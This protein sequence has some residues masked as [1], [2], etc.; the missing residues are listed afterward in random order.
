MDN[1][2]IFVTND[3]VNEF[4]K[5]VVDFGRRTKGPWSF[6]AS[7]GSLA[8]KLYQNLATNITFK[9]QAARIGFY[10]GDERVVDPDDEASNMFN[11]RKS[12]LEPLK[13]M[14]V[15]PQEFPPFTKNEFGRLSQRLHGN[16]ATDYKIFEGTAEDYGL[17]IQVAPKPWLIHLGVGQDGHTASLFPNSP[18]LF[19]NDPNKLYLANYDPSRT[20]PYCRLTLSLEAIS[21]A[22]LVII[23]ANG[24]GKSKI[25]EGLLDG[26]SP[27]PV[28][29]IRAAKVNLIIDYEAASLVDKS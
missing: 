3:I 22:E 15:I 14:G 28:A 21:Q 9:H 26:H 16:P 1:L 4:S 12:L 8:P 6:F 2:H 18:A 7:G 13:S 27:L 29:Q 5:R 25:I 17:M 10:L 20:N 24:K 11:L 19:E 23:T